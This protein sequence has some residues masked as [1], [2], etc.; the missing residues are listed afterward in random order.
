MILQPV[1]QSLD[2]LILLGLNLGSGDFCPKLN[3]AGQI[4]HG[5][6]RRWDLLQL[7][8]LIGQFAQ[9]A[10]NHGKTLIMLVFRILREHPQLQLIIIPLFF[11]FRQ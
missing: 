7:L 8:N 9:A 2:L 4:L 5:D 11:A 1:C 6:R 3:N 10:A